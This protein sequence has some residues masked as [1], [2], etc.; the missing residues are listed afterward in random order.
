MANTKLTSKRV[1]IDKSQAVI[2]GIIA[3]A[4]FVTVFSLVASKTLFSQA[5]YQRKVIASKE[6]ARDNIEANVDKVG[7]LVQAYKEFTSTQSNMLDGN[8]KGS[9]A[10]DGDNARLI[11]D[12]LPSKYDFPAVTSSV[13]K[14]IQDRKLKL[15]EITGTDDEVVQFQAS[16]SDN[17]QP[18]DIPIQFKTQGGIKDVRNL[19]E[20]LEKSIRP[21]NMQKL[22]IEGNAGSMKATIETK[23]YYQPEK[24]LKS[25]TKDVQR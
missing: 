22:V 25:K 6:Q 23:T 4:V 1:Q 5:N 20:T 16:Q 13:E 18:I 7:D 3:G 24:L 19:I 11:L 14:M 15:V 21:F 12:A 17:P 9:G 2:V 8:P 10:K